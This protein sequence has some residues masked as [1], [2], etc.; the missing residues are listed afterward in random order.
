MYNINRVITKRKKIILGTIV[1]SFFIC[2]LFVFIYS[3]IINNINYNSKKYYANFYY[4]KNIEN[5]LIITVNDVPIGKVIKTKINDDNLIEATISINSK[6]TNRVREDSV[7]VSYISYVSGR[8]N[9]IKLYPGKGKILP[10]LSFIETSD[11]VPGKILMM[12]YEKKENI[13]P[14]L[15]ENDFFIKE[16][17]NAKQI[18]NNIKEIY[19]KLIKIN[20]DINEGKY[21]TIMSDKDREKLVKTL[22]TLEKTL[23][24]VSVQIE[25]VKNIT[26]VLSDNKKIPELI[27][28]MNFIMEDSS[29]ILNDI[30]IIMPQTFDTIISLERTIDNIK[31]FLINIELL[32]DIK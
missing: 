25:S 28:A 8:I 11:S 16:I 6:Y 26:V 24:N 30:L 20:S 13:Q 27:E 21:D 1:I 19:I 14:T 18:E 10:P 2:I 7:I 12:E 29:T 23:N 5:G 32:Y 31:K 15:S 22:E 3:L 9:N 4:A 17:T